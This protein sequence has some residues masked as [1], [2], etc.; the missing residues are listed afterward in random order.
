[1]LPAT[2][3]TPT[4]H[5]QAREIEFTAILSS[6]IQLQNLQQSNLSPRDHPCTKELMYLIAIYVHTMELNYL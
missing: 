3:S 2:V 4:A 6:N 1:M 5:T